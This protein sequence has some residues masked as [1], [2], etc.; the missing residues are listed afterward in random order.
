MRILLTL[1]LLSFVTT[2]GLAT[3]LRNQVQ[4]LVNKKLTSSL[5][6][7]AKINEID[8]HGC[9]ALHYAAEL[10]NLPLVE[11]LTSY[12]ADTRVKDNDGLL[13]LDHAISNAYES[14]S[15]Q[16]LLVV[17]HIL[18]KTW[19]VN[20]QD[21]QGWLPLTWAI[22]A[23]DLQR[24]KEL[25]DKMSSIPIAGFSN[26]ANI[27]EVADL[28]GNSEIIKLLADNKEQSLMRIRV[29][30]AI[31]DE[32]PTVVKE[33]LKKGFDPNMTDRHGGTFLYYLTEIEFTPE[34]R[35]IA[36]LLLE[37][38]A[39]PNVANNRGWTPLHKSASNKNIGMTILLLEAGANPNA[40]GR[41]GQTPLHSS[42][43]LYISY[44]KTVETAR[45][46]L[47]YGAD[48]NAVDNRGWTPLHE[49]ASQGL[50]GVGRLLL[51]YGADPNAVDNE[52][53]TPTYRHYI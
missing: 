13:P 22:A 47:E 32:N 12:G 45:L 31:V 29:W 11:F 44:K 43:Y 10:G 28:M 37:A 6:I 52:G 18:E 50:V 9:N 30:N 19:G 5:P 39:N 51:E 16:Q 23:N 14:K 1:S 26:R 40:V 38:G 21:R 46:L 15:S 25:L 24:V 36:R 49:S 53:Q 41:D 8:R 33:A 2:Q 27:F 42:A 48:P 34:I 17:S 3:A 7:I 4:S 20:G 35:E